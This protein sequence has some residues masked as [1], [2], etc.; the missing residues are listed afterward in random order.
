MAA[1]TRGVGGFLLRQGQSV[2]CCGDQGDKSVAAA[3]RVVGACGE[4]GSLWRQGWSVGGCGE[5]GSR[6]V[7]GRSVAGRSVA[8]AFNYLQLKKMRSGMKFRFFLAV[9]TSMRICI[10]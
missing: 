4:K 2:R 7:V 8:G 6:S 9:T 3:K 5:K 10:L 1:S